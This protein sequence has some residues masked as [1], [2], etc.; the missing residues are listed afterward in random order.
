MRD[1]VFM[2]SDCDTQLVQCVEENTSICFFI[3]KEKEW[4]DSSAITRHF[5]M[6]FCHFLPLFYGFISICVE[7]RWA[8]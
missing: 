8:F 5:D 7:W 2:S 3:L 6:M 1:D 4:K